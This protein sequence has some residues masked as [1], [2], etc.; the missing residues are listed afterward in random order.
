VIDHVSLVKL[1]I[2]NNYDIRACLGSLEIVAL[3]ENY[4]NDPI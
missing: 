3:N 2:A 4:A 1:C